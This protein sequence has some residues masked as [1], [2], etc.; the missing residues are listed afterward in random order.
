MLVAMS[1][2]IALALELGTLTYLLIEVQRVVPGF[3]HYV[4]LEITA[5]ISI[6]L[7]YYIGTQAP[8]ARRHGLRKVTSGTGGPPRSCVNDSVTVWVFVWMLACVCVGVG[9]GRP[10][11][12]ARTTRLGS[13]GLRPLPSPSPTRASCGTCTRC[14]SGFRRGSGSPGASSSTKC[15]T[16]GCGWLVGPTIVRL[17]AFLVTFGAMLPFLSIHPVSLRSAPPLYPHPFSNVLFLVLYL[18]SG[19]PHA[20]HKHTIRR[21]GL[22]TVSTSLESLVRGHPVSHPRVCPQG[23]LLQCCC[24]NVQVGLWPVVLR[25]L[26]LLYGIT[27]TQG[28]SREWTLLVHGTAPIATF[29][30]V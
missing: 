30:L 10:S 14:T 15:S 9:W 26:A 22:Y 5:A 17:G 27:L 20:L 28:P 3:T 7:F 29:V 12:Q 11:P 4:V 6:A 23:S 8:E 2:C 13:T 21:G 19:W 1:R 25:Y 18:S 24:G 16:R